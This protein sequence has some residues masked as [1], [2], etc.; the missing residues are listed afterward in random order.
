METK[1]FYG[2]LSAG[3]RPR[4]TSGLIQ[5]EFK[6]L[7]TRERSEGPGMRS[8]D[9]H[10]LEKTDVP[11]QAGSANLIFLHFFFFLFRPSNDYMIPTNIGERDLLYSVY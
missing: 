6:G 1:K 8:S 3:W 9:V 2:T 7:I 4:K 10:K 5:P 11:P